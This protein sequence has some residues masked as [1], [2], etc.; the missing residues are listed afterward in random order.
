MLRSHE[1]EALGL[2]MTPNPPMQPNTLYVRGLDLGGLDD[3][4]VLLERAVDAFLRA[5]RYTIM[6][7]LPPEARG[8]L[9]LG[10]TWVPEAVSG[11]EASRHG[12]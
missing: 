2:I 8:S 1:R 9:D 3:D 6:L 4:Q 11:Q 10:L 5:A 12:A 7:R